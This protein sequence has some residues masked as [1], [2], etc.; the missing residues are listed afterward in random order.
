MTKDKNNQEP[1]AEEPDEK[2]GMFHDDNGN[3][4]VMRVMSIIALVA[5]IWFGWLTLTDSITSNNEGIYL[6]TAF[7]L[8]AFAPKALQKFIE[9][10][11]PSKK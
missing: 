4:S 11:Y 5:A 2:Y 8:A 7:L 1:T 10:S 6:T 9:N 3:R